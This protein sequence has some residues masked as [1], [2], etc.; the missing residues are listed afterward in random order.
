MSNVVSLHN[1]DDLIERL[2]HLLTEA[3]SGTLQGLTA[4]VYRD[5][6]IDFD[7][8]STM[9]D[10]FAVLGGL[11]ILKGVMVDSLIGGDEE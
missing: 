1:N 8:D 7:L 3:K 5:G 6:V 2:E 4:V 9:I 11:E 10:D